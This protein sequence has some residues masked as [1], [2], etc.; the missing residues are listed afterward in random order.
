MSHL[1]QKTQSKAADIR[2]IVTLN[3]LYDENQQLQVEKSGGKYHLDSDFPLKSVFCY[4]I[5]FFSF[6][7][8]LI[9]FGYTPTTVVTSVCKYQAIASVRFDR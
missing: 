5:Q 8:V 3:H 4:K 9:R 6:S 2:D 7:S 1:C